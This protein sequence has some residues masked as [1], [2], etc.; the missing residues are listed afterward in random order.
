MDMCSK[1]GK[2]GEKASGKKV[3]GSKMEGD[4]VGKAMQRSGLAKQVLV[5]SQFLDLH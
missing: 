3:M 1:D 5:F 4:E 2:E